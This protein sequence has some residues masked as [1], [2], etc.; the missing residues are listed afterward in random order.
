MIQIALLAVSIA[1]IVLG[2]KG[3]TASGIPLSKETTLKGTTGKI[4]GVICIL[5]GVILVP[6][7]MLVAWAF[8][9]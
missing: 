1:L 9:G 6:I 7:F 5:A 8:S 3:F 4:V 2:A